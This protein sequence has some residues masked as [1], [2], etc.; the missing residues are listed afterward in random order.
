MISIRLKDIGQNQLG[1]LDISFLI[2]A[3]SL[4]PYHFFFLHKSECTWE[5][6]EGMAI[7]YKHGFLSFPESC[8]YF[9]CFEIS[10]SAYSFLLPFAIASAWEREGGIKEGRV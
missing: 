1:V 3:Q 4:H 10:P 2:H 7:H 8:F 6:G 5:V 9:S